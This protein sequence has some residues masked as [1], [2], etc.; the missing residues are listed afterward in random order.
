MAQV[1]RGD[2]P[3]AWHHVMNRALARR[4]LFDARAALR[5]FLPRL[6]REVRTGTIEVHCWCLMTTH[7]HLLVRSPLGELARGMQRLQNAYFRHFNRRHRRDGPLMRGRFRSR[8][9]DSE[10]YRRVLV[11]YIDHS[12]ARMCSRPW[13]YPWGSAMRVVQRTAPI[14]HET[15]WIEGVVD[16][17]REPDKSVR[18]AYARRFGAR[19]SAGVHRW[20][21]ERLKHTTSD[22]ERF[23][24]LIGSAALGIRSW[25]DAKAP[26]ADGVR[27]G[28]PVADLGTV[29]AEARKEGLGALR[30]ANRGRPIDADLVL[31]VA[32][33]RSLAGSSW[34]AISLHV[35]RSETECKRLFRVHHRRLMDASCYRQAIG[36]GASRALGEMLDGR[37]R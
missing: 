8:R 18:D 3:G 15:R 33:L 26:L 28:G 5:Y 32:A 6:A 2:R 35:E 12:P 21:E 20:V 31:R 22:A 29:D 34:S 13:D 27:V 17:L 36:R 19:P 9:V 25:M 1:N 16:E 7:F 10:E 4:P 11:R 23:D 24:D 14:W 37:P 30:L